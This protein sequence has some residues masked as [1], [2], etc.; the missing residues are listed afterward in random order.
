[1]IFEN[2]FMLIFFRIALT[3]VSA[4]LCQLLW[5]DILALLL[6]LSPAQLFHFCSFRL[7]L[8]TSSEYTSRTHW[9]TCAEAWIYISISILINLVSF[10]LFFVS[11]NRINNACYFSM[12]KAN[13]WINRFVETLNNHHLRQCSKKTIYEEKELLSLDPSWIFEPK[14]LHNVPQKGFICS[15]CNNHQ[16]TVKFTSIYSALITN[17]LPS[18]R[19]SKNL[20]I[21]LMR[22]LF[23]PIIS[24]D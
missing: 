17:C 2:A 5:L 13:V 15:F 10:Y 1:M 3:S 18:S 12:L 11:K 23:L 4:I 8:C 19:E 9:I 20:N 16:C 6:Q 14:N 21:C 22:D 24:I 7:K